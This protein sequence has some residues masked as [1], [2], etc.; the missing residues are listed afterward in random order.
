MILANV[1]NPRSLPTE[2]LFDL[3]ADPGEQHNLFATQPDRTQAMR[4]LLREVLT[5]AL[6]QAVA[7]EIG[8]L[9]AAVQEK[10]RNLGY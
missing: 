1:G 2:A 5:L 8:S 3:V 6:E 4:G 10:L 7:G 9:D